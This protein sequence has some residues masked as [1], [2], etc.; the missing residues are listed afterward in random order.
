MSELTGK[1]VA[2]T[3]KDLLQISN[4]NKGIDATIRYIED[5]E[6]HP[7]GIGVSTTTV[8]L[9]ANHLEFTSKGGDITTRG[10]VLPSDTDMYDLGREARR[11]KNV[12]ASGDV[13][14]GNNINIGGQINFLD[15]NDDSVAEQLKI[16]STT[17]NLTYVVSNDGSSSDNVILV[18]SY[19]VMN[20]T[21]ESSSTPPAMSLKTLTTEISACYSGTT[22]DAGANH[23][24][25]PA[26]TLGQLKT[27]IGVVELGPINIHSTD[28]VDAT[29]ITM[30]GGGGSG[31]A[32]TTHS[33][34]LQYSRAGWVLLSKSSEHITTS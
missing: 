9:C 18:Q 14:A 32:E 1:T 2:S 26:G 7:G 17:R 11:Y 33:V 10:D 20:G 28:M 22:P 31:V 25:L 23:V 6:G 4:T 8:S 16:D 3:Y 19:N 13:N 21:L 12:H 34:T 30:A 29:K 27:I 15:N 24:S 5:G